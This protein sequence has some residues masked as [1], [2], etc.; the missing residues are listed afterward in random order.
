MYLKNA[1]FKTFSVAALCLLSNDYFPA[2]AASENVRMKIELVL[3]DST[4]VVLQNFGLTVR[5]VNPNSFAVTIRGFT[6]GYI[7][8]EIHV[9]LG[10][11]ETMHLRHGAHDSAWTGTPI[12]IPP[13]GVLEQRRFL[14]EESSYAWPGEPGSFELV[15]HLDVS[16]ARV[17]PK[18]Q[19]HQIVWDQPA[20]KLRVRP[21]GLR[22]RL[23]MEFLQQRLQEYDDAIRLG[24]AEK[25]NIFRAML[26]REFLDR[27]GDTAYAPEIRWETARLLA[28]LL[29]NRAIPPEELEGMLDLFEK[30]LTFCLLKGGAYAE[31]FVKGDPRRAG[32]EVLELA[33]I[34]RRAELFKRIVEEVDRKYPDDEEG[35]LFRRLVVTGLTES[36]D[37]AR[38]QAAALR[39]RFPDG[40]YLRH[41]D[42]VLRQL[43]RN[44]ASE[45]TKR[46]P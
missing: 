26:F 27:F 35:I 13:E 33:L 25:V 20:A 32:Y 9:L 3:D 18:G 41:L 31:E 17:G 46:D 30:C 36:L 43:E 2:V 42:S 19:D 45:N 5:I 7:Q 34:H 39:E 23:A 22:D 6:M 21:Q 8:P 4:C 10:N 16:T 38:E 44:N 40:Q 28:G 12:T 11:E 1:R 29:G 15:G 24:R 14:F 37:K